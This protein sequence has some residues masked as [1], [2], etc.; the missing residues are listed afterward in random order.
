MFIFNKD[1]GSNSKVLI[2]VS[3]D[4]EFKELEQSISVKFKFSF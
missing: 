3:C 4:W 2:I 1:H